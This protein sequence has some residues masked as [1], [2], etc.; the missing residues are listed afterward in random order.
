M[1]AHRESFHALVG[2][3]VTALEAAL[4][5][6]QKAGMDEEVGTLTSSL[7]VLSV[8]GGVG[9]EAAAVAAGERGDLH[10]LLQLLR[11]GDDEAKEHAAGALANLAENE[12]DREKIAAA[13]AIGPLVELARSG[14][15]GT[16]EQA[17]RAL[18]NLA[19]MHVD[20]KHLSQCITNTRRKD[21][22][23]WARELAETE[24][25]EGWQTNKLTMNTS[26]W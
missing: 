12:A 14:S 16:K 20:P 25:Q 7:R 21:A 15:A 9:P 11:G 19:H 1:S 4:V 24:V 17:A 3:A 18:G 13:G 23:R 5:A 8:S 26:L 22:V 2:V 6:A 10:P